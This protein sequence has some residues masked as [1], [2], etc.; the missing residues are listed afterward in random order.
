MIESIRAMHLEDNLDDEMLAR[1]WNPPEE[2]ETCNGCVHILFLSS[3]SYYTYLP[4]MNARTLPMHDL[5]SCVNI[6]HNLSI[7]YHIHKLHSS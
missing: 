5:M 7:L 2:Q 1:L 3:H 4:Y 6:L